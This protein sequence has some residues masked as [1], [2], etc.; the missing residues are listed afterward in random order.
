MKPDQQSV[1]AEH[2]L[3][4]TR[5]CPQVKAVCCCLKVAGLKE[6]LVDSE[7]GASLMDSASSWSRSSTQGAVT[8]SPSEVTTRRHCCSAV[9]P[10]TS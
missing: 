1:C 3:P 10:D 7:D 5:V 9:C 6:Q 4:L 2:V 8:L